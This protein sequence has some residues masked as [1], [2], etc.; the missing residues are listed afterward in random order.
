[1]V[2]GSRCIIAT[3]VAVG[4]VIIVLMVCSI[5]W[6]F[7]KTSPLQVELYTGHLM[8]KQLQLPVFYDQNGVFAMDCVIGN[9]TVSVVIDTGSSHLNVGSHRCSQCRKHTGG[10]ILPE[11]MPSKQEIIL[12]NDKILYGS[13]EDKVDWYMTRVRFPHRHLADKSVC[14]FDYTDDTDTNTNNNENNNN[15]VNYSEEEGNGD[16]LYSKRMPLAVVQSRKGISNYNIVGVGYTT[17]TSYHRYK[18]Q[19]MHMFSR[20]T[21]EFWVKGNNGQLTIGAEV[22]TEPSTHMFRM[23]KKNLFLGIRLH[24][25]IFN[26]TVSCRKTHPRSIPREIIFDTG[27]NMM[28]LPNPLFQLFESYCLDRSYLGTVSF[29]FQNLNGDFV[30]IKLDSSVYLWNPGQVG[31]CIIEPSNNDFNSIIWGSLFMNNFSLWFDIDKQE[32]GIRKLN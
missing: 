1:M 19:F 16:N 21:I 5:V 3:V 14:V 18:L 23:T 2:P 29:V 32:V 12:R 27:S 6:E 4:V 20:K 28:D 22:P 13:Q 25:V 17:D 10:Y 9:Q 8:K 30:R 11:N 7:S 26:D 15:T 31:S 24:D